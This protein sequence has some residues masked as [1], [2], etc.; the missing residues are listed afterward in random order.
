MKLTRDDFKSKKFFLQT[1][2]S[3]FADNSTNHKLCKN[4]IASFCKGERISFAEKEQA[5]FVI[6]PSSSPCCVSDFE[7]RY[8]QQEN[9]RICYI[10]EVA[11]ILVYQCWERMSQEKQFDTL[12]C[13]L[14]DKPDF[15]T[16]DKT[17]GKL[18]KAAAKSETSD[19]LYISK[20]TN[21]GNRVL[22]CALANDDIE[23]FKGILEYQP[24]TVNNIDKV[25]A[26]CQSATNITNYIK[27]QKARLFSEIDSISKIPVESR[28]MDEWKKLFKLVRRNGKI[29]LT[30]YIGIDDSVIIPET[31]DGK[32]VVLCDSV[33]NTKN[34]KRLT[35][36]E[37]AE[38][39][40]VSDK[41]LVRNKVL[42]DENG[43]LIQND[44][45]YGCWIPEK[46]SVTIPDGVKHIHYGVFSDWYFNGPVHFSKIGLPINPAASHLQKVVIPPGLKTIGT[47][48]FSGCGI[49]KIELP[50]S[51]TKVGVEAFYGCSR[52]RSATL[53][54][55]LLRIEERAFAACAQLRAIKI[56]E[57]VT[58]IGKS[59]FAGCSSLQKIYI[60]Y[61]VREMEDYVFDRCSA[62][63]EIKVDKNNPYFYAENN[64]LIRKQDNAVI[65]IG[66]EESKKT[67][68][69]F[70]EGIEKIN[71]H[72]F[73]VI[74]YFIRTIS[75]PGSLKEIETRAFPSMT[76]LESVTFSEGLEQIG[77]WAFSGCVQLKKASIPASVIKIGDNA[78]QGCEQL[79]IEAPANS[80]AIQYAKENGIQYEEI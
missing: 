3:T 25:A 28:T 74:N 76:Y 14:R 52:L 17:T 18:L 15:L 19:L 23:L 41:A 65:A 80:Y 59:A 71:C 57:S 51:V 77:S 22:E 6:Y 35:K 7:E 33:F 37:I 29:A 73:F 64:I 21:N 40:E 47:F 66:Y 39:V 2:D 30:G 20:W 61:N 78:F 75:F 16:K 48:A 8:E 63:S 58:F 12:I 10:S 32:P 46:N 67:E 4:I 53:S 1:N 69:R 49:R 62:L 68:L 34:G 44:T 5:D 55:S 13:Y 54:N 24:L 70:P 36:I 45:L 60:P 26:R 42:K 79:V 38:G 9:Q 72:S 56:P 50:N 31:I 27:D 43:F 11:F